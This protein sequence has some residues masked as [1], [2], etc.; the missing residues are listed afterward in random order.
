[1]DL[2]DLHGVQ[3]G[4]ELVADPAFAIDQD[5]R[6]VAAN[7]AS[8]L[9]IGESMQRWIGEVPLELVHPDD[10][11]IVLSSF[12]EVSD[13]V[14]GSP[15]EIRLRCE[16]G[17]R[18]VEA[19]GATHPTEN[20][21][22]VVVSMRDLTER[23]KWELA[24]GDT[25]LFRTVVEH[26]S[27]LMLLLSADGVITAATGSFNRQLGH[28][29]SLVVGSHLADWIIADERDRFVADLQRATEQ[30]QTSLFE[31]TFA[32]ASRLHIPYQFSVANLIFPGLKKVSFAC[33][34]KLRECAMPR[35]PTSQRFLSSWTKRKPPRAA[36]F[37]PT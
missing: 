25:E 24:S 37:S 34:C 8:E 9:L 29:L 18:L 32:T 12:T 5:L 28:D 33:C 10:L 36:A 11:P 7:H 23:R 26:A 15:I 22:I 3:A 30:P 27:V 21:H 35:C 1:M 16:S 2:T 4:L 31:A 19:I 14:F 13:K 20:G 6:I 17:Y